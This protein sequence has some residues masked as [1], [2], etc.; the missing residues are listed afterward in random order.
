MVFKN[1]NLCASQKLRRTPSSLS[2]L[3]ASISL[4]PDVLLTA[5]VAQCRGSWLIVYA[6]CWRKRPTSLPATMIAAA[7]LLTVL[8]SFVSKFLLIYIHDWN[9]LLIKFSFSH[10]TPLSFA[11]KN[12]IRVILLHIFYAIMWNLMFFYRM[13]HETVYSTLSWFDWSLRSQTTALLLQ[14]N[15]RQM[16]VHSQILNMF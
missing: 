9:R 2:H 10:Q 11:K 13:A 5:A 15:L 4:W 3:L 6:L 1:K 16:C 12:L 7:C 14:F 8:L